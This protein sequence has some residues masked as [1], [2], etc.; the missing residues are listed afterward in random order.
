M[1]ASCRCAWLSNTR[2]KMSA[3]PLRAQGRS[4]LAVAN[5][6]GFDGSARMNRRRLLALPPVLTAIALGCGHHVTYV[7]EGADASVEAPKPDAAKA[8]SD[9]NDTTDDD[10]DDVPKE[11]GA[12]AKAG[13]K[14]ASAGFDAA[15]PGASG[16]EC[17]LNYD[18]QLALRCEC[19]DGACACKSGARGK[20][21][22]GEPCTDG[23][24]CVSAI[25]L[26]GPGNAMLCSDQ[27]ATAADCVP[28]LPIC[29]KI[30]LVGQICIRSGP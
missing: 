30:A 17:S 5:A 3:P 18:C 10:D 26:E 24:D 29:K 11:A 7:Y 23:D 4:P 6:Y 9:D 20:G 28:K 22:N 15:G 2:E 1:R 19:A 13:P 16:E 14:D 25:C 27:C 8:H 21:K 12:D